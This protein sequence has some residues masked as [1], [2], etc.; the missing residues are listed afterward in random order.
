MGEVL[1]GNVGGGRRLDFTVI[2]PAINLASRL[3]RLARELG[4]SVIASAAFAGVCG[5]RL[6]P[7]G[8]Y[9]LRDISAVQAAFGL[10]EENAPAGNKSH[11]PR[12][13]YTEACPALS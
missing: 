5:E 9:A 13:G 12:A 2:G 1:Y 7:L 10:P 6:S 8:R 4:C 11:D 3:E